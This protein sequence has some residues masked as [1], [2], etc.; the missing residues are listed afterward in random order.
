MQHTFTNST[1][2]SS[3]TSFL[4]TMAW[5]PI[6]R[7]TPHTLYTAHHA[8]SY[9]YSTLLNISASEILICGN[10][11]SWSFYNENIKVPTLLCF[12]SQELPPPP[13][14]TTTRLLKFWRP[15]TKLLYWYNF[16]LPFWFHFKTKHKYLQEPGT[17]K[18]KLKIKCA[19]AEYHDFRE[20]KASVRQEMN[21]VPWIMSNNVYTGIN[22]WLID[23]LVRTADGRT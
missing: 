21:L 17:R 14:H 3:A 12:P 7:S 5:E 20:Y 6:G 4:Q 18:R 13:P 22:D 23:W 8:H 9:T 19:C 10:G 15:F 2:F 11:W 16:F 1:N